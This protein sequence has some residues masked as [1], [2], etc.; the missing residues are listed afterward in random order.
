MDVPSNTT[1]NVW[2]MTVAAIELDT[3]E[4]ARLLATS[5][6]G[7]ELPSWPRN[8]SG[9]DLTEAI[10]SVVRP[11]DI[12]AIVI[13]GS[14]VRPLRKRLFFFDAWARDVDVMV[15]SRKTSARVR[16]DEHYGVTCG[17]GYGDSWYENRR[18]RGVLD[19][20]VV[21]A[22]AFAC[23]YRRHEQIA[24]DLFKDGVLLAGEWS[25]PGPSSATHGKGPYR[26]NAEPHHQMR[27]FKQAGATY[28]I[29][30]VVPLLS[31]QVSG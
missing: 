27:R 13:F 31:W 21:T 24:R 25:A 23:A 7:I 20:V 1:Y 5:G 3:G 11:D 10:T 16:G 8:I 19:V 26:I 28:R 29:E 12:D 9:A 6:W 18:E 14:S 2:A 15:M 30:G 22:E 4:A 17:D